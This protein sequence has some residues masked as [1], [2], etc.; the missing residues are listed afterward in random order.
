MALHIWPQTLM[1][2][3]PVLSSNELGAKREWLS[4]FPL[5]FFLEILYSSRCYMPFIDI[6][7][8]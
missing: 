8:K 5:L 6:D 1:I 7:G 3:F 4:S 2:R